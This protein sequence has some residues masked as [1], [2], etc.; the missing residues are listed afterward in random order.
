[1]KRPAVLQRQG[2]RRIKKV[3]KGERTQIGVIVG[4]NTKARLLKSMKE[5][6]RTIS[7]EVE[8]LIEKAHAYDDVVATVTRAPG[9]PHPGDLEEIQRR[10]VEADLARLG[11]P[12]RAPDHRRQGVEDLGRARISGHSGRRR[13]RAGGSAMKGHL[14]RRGERSWRLKYDLPRARPGERQQRSVTLRGTRK[15]A[16]AEAAKILASVAG[17]IH[18]DPSGETVASFVERWLRDWADANISHKTFTRYEQLLRKHLCAHVGSIPLQKLRA[19]DLQAIYAAMAK[20]GL[21]DRTRLHLH[22]V[23]R[24]C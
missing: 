1:M 23:C 13:R 3:P 10:N 24:R 9:P 11:Y 4:G 18:V 22:R 2:G 17:G 8:H 19:A 16:Q 14:T 15:E 6:G 21:A 5:S 20:D 7:R 12:M